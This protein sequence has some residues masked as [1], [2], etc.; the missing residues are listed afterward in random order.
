MFRPTRRLILELHLAGER[1]PELAERLVVWHGEFPALAIER[2]PDV[3]RERRHSRSRRCPSSCSD[4]AHLDDLDSLE[5]A[6]AEFSEHVGRLVDA[7]YSAC[8][9]TTWPT[10]VNPQDVHRCAARAE[11]LSVD[12]D[13]FDWVVISRINFGS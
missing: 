3:L 2:S 4:A 6:S 10:S 9:P 11:I 13:K 5:T 7:L 8:S 12:F 1:H